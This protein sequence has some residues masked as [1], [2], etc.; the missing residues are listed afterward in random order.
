MRKAF[1]FALAIVLIAGITLVSNARSEGMDSVFETVLEEYKLAVRNASAVYA[2]ESFDAYYNR[3]FSW[4]PLANVYATILG[5]VESILP[6][7]GYAL[8]DLNKD[9]KPELLLL[10]EGAHVLA[11]FARTNSGDLKFFG[12]KAEDYPPDCYWSFLLSD[13]SLATYAYG[14]ESGSIRKSRLNGNGTVMKQTG[15]IGWRMEDWG[16]L[17]IYTRD[18]SGKETNVPLGKYEEDEA[19]TAYEEL[20]V[21]Y[22]ENLLGREDIGYLPLFSVEEIAHI[23]ASPALETQFGQ[24]ATLNHDRT[25]NIRSGPGTEF[26]QIGEAYPGASFYYTGTTVNKYHE[27]IYPNP[28]TVRTLAYVSE[29]LAKISE[30]APE[31]VVFSSMAGFVRVNPDTQVY[32]DAALSKKTKT[33]LDGNEKVPYAGITPNGLYAVLYSASGETW[34]QPLWIGY[35]QPKDVVA[36]IA[37]DEEDW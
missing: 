3:F 7:F 37:P 22:D 6:C 11:V 23:S 18:E 27:I 35:I 9:R 2:S 28:H 12:M 16:N 36:V 15:G 13:N 29:S 24:K 19:F 20:N 8:R 4:E 30:T 17:V 33:M 14:V 34:A 26:S 10:T 21:W 31:D 25:V 1:S 5:D 32:F